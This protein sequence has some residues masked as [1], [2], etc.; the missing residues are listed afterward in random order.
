MTER[1]VV[2]GGGMSG[3][4]AAEG[5]ESEGFEVLLIDQ[6]RHHVY[7][8]GIPS[9]INGRSAESLRFD[10]DQHLRKTD[11]EYTCEEIKKFKPDKKQVEA[12][13]G[14]YDYDY[15]VVALGG[16][17]RSPKFSLNYAEDFYSLESSEEGVEKVEGAENAIVVGA[18]YTGLEVALRLDAEGVE[19]SVVDSSTRPLSDAS[20]KV[21]GKVLDLLNSR[22]IGFMGDRRVMEIPNYG[23]EFEEGDERKADLVVWCGGLEAPEVVQEGF[24]TGKSGINVNR[25]LSAADFENVYA[26]GRCADIEGGNRALESVRQGK[27]VARNIG[28]DEG[29]LEEYEP[30]TGK[31]I[32]SSPGSGFMVRG[33]SFSSGRHANVLDFVV[34]KR[35]FA[36]LRGRRILKGLMPSIDPLLSLM[37]D[38]EK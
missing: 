20:S 7:R 19:T 10:I 13:Y 6:S 30:S 34:E 8:P 26:V 29:L 16:E 36:G 4:A 5:L 9:M 17:V 18:G 25:G 38:K 12:E 1:V 27:Q 3:L 23:V 35:Y 37:D 33:E 14:D 32:V 31:R 15:L 2:A 28:R 21:S 24:N 22:E 11:I